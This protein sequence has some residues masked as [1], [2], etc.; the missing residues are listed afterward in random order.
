MVRAYKFAPLSY[1]MP[2]CFAG[3]GPHSSEGD[4][5]A[6][7][8]GEPDAHVDQH[9]LPQV[10]RRRTTAAPTLQR[11]WNQGMMICSNQFLAKNLGT[12]N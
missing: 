11:K 4:E 6:A 3:F 5:R 1:E 8:G 9:R 12:W 10:L 2:S 7:G